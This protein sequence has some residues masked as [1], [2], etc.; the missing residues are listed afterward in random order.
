[1]LHLITCHWRMMPSLAELLLTNF[2]EV[3]I[4]M[5][6]KQL[7]LFYCVLFK[8]FHITKNPPDILKW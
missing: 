8:M 7:I 2:N 4:R 5:F 3:C 1:M 6:V